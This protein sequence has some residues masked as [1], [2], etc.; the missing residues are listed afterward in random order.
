MSLYSPSILVSPPVRATQAPSEEDATLEALM[1]D[2]I[3]AIELQQSLKKR[4]NAI[5]KEK[6][7]RAEEE[8][9]AARMALRQAEENTAILKETNR[10][11]KDRMTGLEITENDDKISVPTTPRL[12]NQEEHD[13]ALTIQRAY[14]RY[15]KRG[16]RITSLDQWFYAYTNISPPPTTSRLRYLLTLR[17]PLPHFMVCLEAYREHL[18]QKKRNLSDQLQQANHET[19]KDILARLTINDKYRKTATHIF[20][21]V[22]PASIL[23]RFAVV[24]TLCADM[25][26]I[27]RD[28]EQFCKDDQSLK[29][30]LKLAQKGI[31]QVPTGGPGHNR[32]I[33]PISSK[34][35]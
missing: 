31:V 21:R 26:T 33:P 30:H 13:A 16:E 34:F 28:L 35:E 23:H 14:R 8:E 1:R 15:K 7:E 10:I 22:R 19:L 25:T 27:S 4:I 24:P 32:S 6:E 11:M 12:S 17:G 2:Y 3:H 29:E 20:N 9:D 5:M 18:D